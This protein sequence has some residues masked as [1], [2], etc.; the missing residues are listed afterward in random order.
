LQPLISAAR[1]Q[2]R[3]RNIDFLLVGLHER[4]PLLGTARKI[5]THEYCTHLFLACWA[6]GETLVNLLDDRPVHLELGCL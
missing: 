4:D 1:R 3:L 6:D 5:A 2:L